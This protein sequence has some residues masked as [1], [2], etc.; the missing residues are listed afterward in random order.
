VQ[1]IEALALV[2]RVGREEVRKMPP[3]ALLELPEE[4]SMKHP[5]I[6]DDELRQLVRQEF[7]LTWDPF[8]HNG[9]PTLQAEPKKS[10]ARSFSLSRGL[11]RLTT[12]GK[13]CA[14]T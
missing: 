12:L 2:V 8:N 10:R 11:P 14:S 13:F 5:I 3:P 1:R 7:L 9:L 4:R 6:W